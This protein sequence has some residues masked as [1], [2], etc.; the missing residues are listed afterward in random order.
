MFKREVPVN[1]SQV[2]F[3]FWNKLE[4]EESKTGEG[5]SFT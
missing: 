2:V 4:N 3:V 1:V 5:Q